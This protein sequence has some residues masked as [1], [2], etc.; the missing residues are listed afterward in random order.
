MAGS[1]PAIVGGTPATQVHP[2]LGSLQLEEH[3]DPDWGT[4]GVTLFNP[5]YGEANA[6][7]VTNEGSNSRAEFDTCGD[8]GEPDVYTDVS[9]YVPWILSV[10]YSEPGYTA[11]VASA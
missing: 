8:V 6:H 10:I 11:A 9:Y 1:S 3:G 7:C 2:Y 4:C 5:D